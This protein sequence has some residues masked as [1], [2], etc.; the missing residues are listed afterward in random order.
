M[1]SRCLNKK[2]W[3][4]DGLARVEHFQFS[5]GLASHVCTLFGPDVIPYYYPRSHHLC[6]LWA[7]ILNNQEFINVTFCFFSQQQCGLRPV[8]DFICVIN[9]ICR[10]ASTIIIFA[11]AAKS[12]YF[13]GCVDSFSP[14]KD[15]DSNVVSKC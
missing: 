3:A 13:Y 9:A 4:C 7:G 14:V 8:L 5:F 15:L 6:S 12:T 2:S 11:I 1:S 10:T